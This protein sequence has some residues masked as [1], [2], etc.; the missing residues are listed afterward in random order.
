M[1]KPISADPITLQVMI[2]S[3]LSIADEMVATLVR[4]A[5]STNIKDRRDCS[6]AIYTPEG[7]VVAQCELGTPLHLGTMCPS[8]KTMLSKYPASSLS[9]GDAIIMNEPYPAGPGHLNDIVMLA[10]VFYNG[11]VVALVANMAHHVDMGGFAPG[12]M[13]FGVSEIFQE[14]LQIP[15]VK[16]MKKGQLDEE[17]FSIVRQNVRTDAEFKGDVMAQVGANHVGQQR[18]K[19]LMDKYSPGVVRFYMEEI[20][21]YSERRMRAGIRTL[22]QGV[23]KFE[24]FIEGDGITDEAIKIAVEISI[25]LD[26]IKVDLRGSSAQVKGPINCREPSVLACVYYTMKCVVD[27]DLVPNSGAYRPIEVVVE[28][29][30]L[31]KA[32][33]P[34]ALC[35]SNIIT[36]Q[37]LVDVMLGALKDAAP[38]R[39]VA[40]STGSMNL[41]TLGG[42][43]AAGGGLFNYIET[44]G[45]GQG[46]LMDKDGASGVHTHMTNTRNAS[47]ESIEA[48]YPLLVERYGLVPD[49]EGAG[50]YR[51]GLGIVRELRL[52]GEEATLT[53]SSDR[54]RVQPWGVSGGKGAKC[55]KCMVVGEKGVEKELPSKITTSIRKGEKIV[56]RTAGGGGWGDPFERDVKKVE[57]DVLE[58]FISVEKAMS[59]YGVAFRDNILAVDLEGTKQLRARLRAERTAGVG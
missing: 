5:Y 22:P 48:T 19:A 57:L 21:N 58:G 26:S 16:L 44:Y 41:L 43:N 17:I 59:D 9:L 24:D 12:S 56:F 23:Y 42:R 10:P 8:V 4:T 53:I 50:L 49:S 33:Y 32:S 31:L 35:N 2:K 29:G 40:A 30:S 36:T 47:I 54:H 25:G 11:E 37:R 55:G 13:P 3:L 1:E 6:C 7:E 38:E 51:G 34:A 18:L 14:G 52:T 15:P 20:M 27:P 28:D 39:V 46:A 45:G